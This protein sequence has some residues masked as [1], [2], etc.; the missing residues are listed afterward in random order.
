VKGE[1]AES[2]VRGSGG[3]GSAVVRLLQDGSPMLVASWLTV[4]GMWRKLP[5]SQILL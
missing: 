1:E 2:G 3:W 4:A 5:S